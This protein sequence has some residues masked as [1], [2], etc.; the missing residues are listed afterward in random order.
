[1][2]SWAFAPGG[3]LIEPQRERDARIAGGG[4][5]RVRLV[6][7]ALGLRDEGWRELG[8]EAAREVVE[9]RERRDEHGA[10]VGHPP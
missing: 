10:V 6:T 5:R 3:P 4:E 2:S 9:R 8:G 1:M 7:L